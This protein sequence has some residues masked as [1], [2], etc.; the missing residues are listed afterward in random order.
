MDR[1]PDGKC[2]AALPIGLP[3]V[4]G[5]CAPL[6]NRILAPPLS[7][8]HEVVR[9]VLSRSGF[10]PGPRMLPGPRTEFHG[11]AAAQG[12]VG[13]G[14]GRGMVRWVLGPLNRAR[15]T[16]FVEHRRP[17][18]DGVCGGQRPNW[19]GPTL[20]RSRLNALTMPY[21]EHAAP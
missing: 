4:A 17:G 2:G 21:S 12:Q 14:Q 9:L 3:S 10:R 16:R 7:I 1:T 15:R 19:L 8:E 18:C 6:P 5:P 13:D 11:R 20:G